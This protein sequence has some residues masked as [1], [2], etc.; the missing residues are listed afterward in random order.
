MLLDGASAG[1]ID[2]DG[3]ASQRGDVRRR[4]RTNG[5]AFR[6]IAVN[7][8]DDR[9][10]AVT[11][12]EVG[13]EGDGVSYLS[14]GY[15]GATVQ[16][17]QKLDSGNFADDIRRLPPD[18]IVLAFGTNEGFNDNLDVNAY[19]AQYEQIVRRLQALRPGAE[20]RAD[21]P[22]RRR[23]PGRPV[24]CR[25]RRPACSVGAD[26]ADRHAGTPAAIAA[27]RCRRS[28]TRCARR[29]ASSPRRIGAAFWDWS[30]VQPRPVRRPGLGGRQS[31]ADGA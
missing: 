23:A 27:S 31:P 7:S 30:S 8:L 11:G 16:L 21:R 29:S 26:G 5:R 19:I 6:E 12:V 18:I 2:L 13:R 28:S 14:I 9:P 22:G 10:V 1:E 20:Y 4:G 3:G 25:G 15:P 17:L 24:P